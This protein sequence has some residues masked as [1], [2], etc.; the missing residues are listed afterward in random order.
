MAY[1]FQ[2]DALFYSTDDEYVDGVGDFVREGACAGAGL[3]VAVPGRRLTLLQAS[4]ADL[5]GR[6]TFTDMEQTGVNPGR[7]IPFVRSFVDAHAGHPV[8]FVGE[9]I[10]A[11]RTGPEIVEAVRHEGL[12]NQAFADTSAH[13]LC[14]YDTRDLPGGVLADARRTHPT[15]LCAGGREPCADYVDPLV[16][17]AAV[18]RPLREPPVVPLTVSVDN[19]LV[20]FRSAV[21]EQAQSAGLDAARVASFVLAANEAAVNTL[22]HAGGDGSARIWHD[23]RELVCELTDAGVIDDPLVGRRVPPADREGGRG[24]W[25]MHQLSDLVELRSGARGTVVRIHM[26]R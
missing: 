22:L 21:K 15:L 18:D 1:R 23:D 16:T 20:G 17:Y 10:W 13:I 2:H 25:L 19:G 14:P 12:I 9:P 4:L 6:V 8:R 11:G 3:L 7:I 26:R 24:I 5:D